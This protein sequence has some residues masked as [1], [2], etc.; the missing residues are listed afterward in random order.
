MRK[1]I[2][3]LFVCLMAGPLLAAEAEWLTNVPEA[4]GQANKEH[5]LI[6]LNFT[7]S[8]WCPNCKILDAEVF[9]KSDFADY[10]RKNLVLVT[11][12]FPAGSHQPA[13][14]QD[15][16]QALAEKYSV[17]GYPTVILLKPDGTVLFKE[18][19]YRG[20]GPSWLIAKI[21]GAKKA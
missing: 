2:L 12:D 9:S 19:G 7:G 16:N 5:K 20:G 21:E 8:D 11:V 6:L 14:L 10:A 13:K 3:S 18:L 1:I 15:A 17:R 4:T